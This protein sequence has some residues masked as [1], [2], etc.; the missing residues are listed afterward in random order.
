[1]DFQPSFSGSIHFSE[2]RDEDSLDIRDITHQTIY[3]RIG[4]PWQGSWYLKPDTWHI[5]SSVSAEAQTSS[6]R[7]RYSLTTQ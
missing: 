1:M 3:M 5:Y 4:L 7:R 6:E 2:D